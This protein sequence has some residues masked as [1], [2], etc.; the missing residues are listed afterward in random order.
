[1]AARTPAGARVSSALLAPTIT[2]GVANDPARVVSRIVRSR[3]VADV[4]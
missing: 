2:I 1:M 3:F 4:S